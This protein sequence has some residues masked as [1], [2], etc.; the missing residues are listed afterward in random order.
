MCLDETVL[1]PCIRPSSSLCASRWRASRGT[2]V[3]FFAP[4]LN[5]SRH[6]DTTH[7][8]TCTPSSCCYIP[9]TT[10]PAASF[11]YR[12]HTTGAPAS[13]PWVRSVS[14]PS[15]RSRIASTWFPTPACGLRRRDEEARTA[16]AKKPMR[17][18]PLSRTDSS[19]R[20]GSDWNTSNPTRSVRR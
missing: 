17:A 14:L 16:K 9:R 10:Y 6:T 4:P 1:V 19:L 12:H 3:C 7:T 20:R 5:A 2:A 8:H 13:R 15:P 11:A 18:V